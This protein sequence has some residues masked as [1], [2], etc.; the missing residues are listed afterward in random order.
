MYTDIAVKFSSP[1][2]EW[3]YTRSVIGPESILTPELHGLY[4]DVMIL[5]PPIKGLRANKENRLLEPP[6]LCP[7]F[8]LV[9]VEVTHD[10]RVWGLGMFTT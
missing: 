9:E 7:Q 6:C 4:L 2:Q 3:H 10:T 5:P 1:C 8:L